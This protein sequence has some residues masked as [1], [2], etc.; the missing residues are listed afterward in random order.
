MMLDLRPRDSEHAFLSSWRRFYDAPYAYYDGLAAL[1]PG[2]VLVVGAGT[3]N[4]VAAAPRRTDRRVTA[5]EIDPAI[6][7][8][9]RALHAEN[10]Y[11][12]PRVRLVVDDARSFF[13]RAPS[14]GYA[15]VVFGFLDSH[16]LLSAFSSVRLD[17]FIYTL[18]GMREVRRLL[19]PGGRAALS[20][21]SNERWIH[22]RLL[23]LLDG[24][25]ERPTAFFVEPTGYANGVL[26]LNQK[27]EPAPVSRRG[28]L[29][30][31]DDWPFLYLRERAI[32]RHNLLFLALAMALS[33]AALLLLPSGERRLRLPYFFL[34]AAFF[35]LE[36]SNVVRMALLYGS[37]W[38]VNT[39][40]FAGILL[41]VLLSNLVA[42]RFRVPL[43]ACLALVALLILAAALVP[44]EAL[45]TLPA[46][47]RA[48]AAVVVFLGPVFFGGLVFARLIESET[49]LYE[50]YGSNVLGAVV[51][52]TAEYLSLVL[53]FRFLLALA[54]AF[55][56]AVFL[57]LRR[58]AAR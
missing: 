12:D 26:Y 23:S 33:A 9:G 2:D 37:T 38:W 41:L 21:A 7:R 54:L 42:A 15:L 32:P 45:L 20:F 5:V 46:W 6:A 52:G 30:P 49:R 8:L 55:Y 31:S 1:P 29:V 17:N 16:R 44:S 39:I 58:S 34:G 11:A 10:P 50:A 56:L 51:G 36:T 14:G 28:A 43:H 47:P 53:G 24:A 4:D 35:L 57:L 25:F 3:G 13:Q 19:A 40:V 48:L 27:T 18:E 22:E